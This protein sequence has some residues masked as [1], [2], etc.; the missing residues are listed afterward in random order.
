MTCLFVSGGDGNSLW[1][2]LA[3]ESR[4]HQSVTCAILMFFYDWE[5]GLEV[6]LAL[7]PGLH[8]FVLAE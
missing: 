1:E 5:D 6:S 8:E 3:M 2:S 4:A 7:S